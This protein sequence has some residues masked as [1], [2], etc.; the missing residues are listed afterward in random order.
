MSHRSHTSAGLLAV[1]ASSFVH[2][3]SAEWVSGRLEP[4]ITQFPRLQSYIVHYTS[5]CFALGYIRYT[6][7][8]HCHSTQWGAMLGCDT[9]C[10]SA[11]WGA[12]LR[13]KTHLVAQGIAPSTS[14]EP[15]SD[16]GPTVIVHS[17][18]TVIARMTAQFPSRVPIAN[19][20]REFQQRVPIES[21]NSQTVQYTTWFTHRNF[22]PALPRVPW[23]RS[24]GPARPPYM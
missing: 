20:N 4:P 14:V 19:S 23:P 3:K 18:P 24:A 16:K 9:H 2:H 22:W 8:T 13:C 10:H 1:R 21:S 12:T 15:R 5:E 17:I 11:Q 6:V 7:R